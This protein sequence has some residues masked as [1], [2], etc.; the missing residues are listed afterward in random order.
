MSNRR[1]ADAGDRD[2]GCVSGELVPNV[3]EDLYQTLGVSREA[4]KDDLQKAYRKLARKYHPDMNPDNKEAHERFKRVQEAYDVL[5]DPDKRAAYDR[6]GADFEKI[7]GG[8]GFQPGSGGA[9]F[10]GLDLDQIFGA[11]GGSGGGAGFENGFHDFFEQI[12]GGRAPGGGTATAGGRAQPR[13]PQRGQNIR[14]ELSIPF[15]KAVLGG[16]AEFYLTRQGQPEKLAVTIPPGVE[17]GSKIRL[18]GQGHPSPAGENGDL[19]LVIQVDSHPYYKLDGR[20]LELKLPVTV[21]EAALGAKVDVPTPHGTIGLTIPAGSNSGRRLRLKG[22]GIKPQSGSPGD[23]LVELQTCLPDA[24][25][26]EAA[27]VLRQ[28]DAACPMQPRSELQWDA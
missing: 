8:G 6:Y 16:Q 14:H 10:D 26:E 11:R 7:R 25:S 27:D 5:S 19:I 21:M 17:T 4:D 24:M 15:E 28:W 22:L 12:L 13:A 2:V 9:S 23:L 3:A 18:R 1:I 20:N